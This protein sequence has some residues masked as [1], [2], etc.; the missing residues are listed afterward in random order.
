[1]N[2]NKKK[3]FMI[4]KNIKNALAWYPVISLLVFF[5]LAFLGSD[6]IYKNQYPS[7]YYKTPQYQNTSSLKDIWLLTTL[8]A[9]LFFTTPT[10]FSLLFRRKQKNPKR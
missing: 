2:A 9:G 1:V 8:I 5:L 7:W 4:N 6:V 10:L 3:Y